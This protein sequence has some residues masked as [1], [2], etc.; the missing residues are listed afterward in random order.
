VQIA[1]DRLQADDR[2]AVELDDETEHA[3]HGRVVGAEVDLEDVRLAAAFLGHLDHR[4]DRRGDARALVDAGGRDRHQ[5]SSENRTGSP[6][7]G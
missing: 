2:L 5:T 1:D 3:V 6:P 4:R 7:I